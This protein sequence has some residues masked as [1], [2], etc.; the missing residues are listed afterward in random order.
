MEGKNH[1]IERGIVPALVAVFG[2][3]RT[4]PVRVRFHLASS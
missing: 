4:R 1:L 2:P 3:N